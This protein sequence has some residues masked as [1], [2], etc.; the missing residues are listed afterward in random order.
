MTLLT[1]TRVNMEQYGGHFEALVPLMAVV[2]KCQKDTTTT[3]SNSY[4]QPQVVAERCDLA[5]P[6]YVVFV[7]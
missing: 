1:E 5:I 2:Y 3:G 4:G 7:G 6:C